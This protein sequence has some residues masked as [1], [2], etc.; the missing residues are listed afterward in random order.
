MG[1]EP[2]KP[3]GPDGYSDRND[4]WVGPDS[5][6]KRMEWSL[7]MAERTVTAV[8][9][10]ETIANN[11]LG[12]L[13]TPRTK[14]VLTSAE[15]PAEAFACCLFRRSS[16]SHEVRYRSQDTPQGVFPLYCRKRGGVW[17]HLFRCSQ[18]PMMAES[19]WSCFCGVQPTACH[20]SL[21]SVT[22]SL[23]QLEMVWPFL[24]PA[25]MA[26]LSILMGSLVLTRCCQTSAV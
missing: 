24:V 15:T 19:W 13:S 23:K 8:V 11:I 9:D 10:V 12:P 16:S 26:V 6:W 17:A 5:V 21:H 2:W 22:R 1:E 14:A 20:W 18:R 7:Q 4:D 25:A 3:S